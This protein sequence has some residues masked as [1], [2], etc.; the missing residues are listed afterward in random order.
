MHGSIPFKLRE[1][2]SAKLLE[3]VDNACFKV[4]KR[5]QLNFKL[6][7]GSREKED[8]FKS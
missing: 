1:K 2:K 5:H 4:E 8:F 6:Y 7:R 3:M